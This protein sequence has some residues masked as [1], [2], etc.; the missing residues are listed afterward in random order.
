MNC[1][2]KPLAERHLF[3]GGNPDFGLFWPQKEFGESVLRGL[4]LGDAPGLAG[5][6]TSPATARGHRGAAALN[7]E[8]SSD[9]TGG[10]GEN[11]GDTTPATFP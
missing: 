3:F 10:F 5:W 11:E 6:P 2:R 8:S 1:K 9:G 4:L 7:S